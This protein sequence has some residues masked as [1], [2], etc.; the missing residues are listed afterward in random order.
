M[1]SDASRSIQPS[2]VPPWQPR[3]AILLWVAAAVLALLSL[4]LFT[5]LE[6]M[7]DEVLRLQVGIVELQ[8]SRVS[9]LSLEEITALRTTA[10][11][12]LAA[13]EQL[14]EAL[15]GASRGRVA[16]LAVLERVIPASLPQVRLT[17]LEQH[18]DRLTIEGTA[19]G[20]LALMAYVGRLRGSPLF[21]DVQ[22]TSSLVTPTPGAPATATP[23]PSPAAT[24]A[25]S[26]ADAHEVD[27]TEP[28]PIE[29]GV[30]QPRSFH[31]NFDVDRA[32][33][34]GRASGRYRVF[35]SQLA[36]GVDTILVITVGTATHTSD[37]RAADDLSSYV[38]FTVPS[39]GDLVVNVMVT[40]RGRFGPDATYV[41][42]AEEL[43]PGEGAGLT[44]TPGTS[45]GSGWT[46]LA[47]QPQLRGRGLLAPTGQGAGGQVLFVI[48]LRLKGYQR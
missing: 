30:A 6:A 39:S 14:Q 2:S 4:P 9:P 10:A 15:L 1:E 23:G 22:V 25:P 5:L 29:L 11:R 37:D 41:L 3:G 33:F 17:G 38:E 47:P 21:E 44:A 7:Q 28:R 8:V 27:D 43:G 18:Q 34:V 16:W 26:G 12:T 20:E 13:E 32:R 35:T 31:P 45:S 46:A 48:N 36:P 24:L 19:E 40:N 42:T